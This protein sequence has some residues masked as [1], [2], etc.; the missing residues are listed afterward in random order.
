MLDLVKENIG[1]IN[2]I[3]LM[4]SVSE[5]Y[6]FGSAVSGNFDKKSDLDFAVKFK[7]TLSP[8]EHGDAFFKLNDDLEELFSRDIDLLSY[9]MVKNPI[10]K[11]EL[12]KTKIAL[13]AAS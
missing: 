7:D 8:L 6:L 1:K 5:L 4:N 13:Y 3:C 9:R 2:A 11:K 10:F 12:D